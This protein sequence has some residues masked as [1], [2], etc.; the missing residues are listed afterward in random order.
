LMVLGGS[1]RDIRE[2]LGVS[3]ERGGS[4]FGLC[5]RFI[6][7]KTRTKWVLVSITLEC[8]DVSGSDQYA[9]SQS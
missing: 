3:V 9:I 4:Y 5:R 8:V 6:F 1:V 7:S 2:I